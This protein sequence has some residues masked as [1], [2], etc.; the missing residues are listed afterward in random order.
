MIHKAKINSSKLFGAKEEEI[1]KTQEKKLIDFREKS[2]LIT[3]EK[4]GE[5]RKT[6]KQ[7]KTKSEKNV[8]KAV[9]FV[10]KKFEKLI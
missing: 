4:I 5:G 8:S 3:E 10:I 7:V 2:K 1:K 9:D 6:A